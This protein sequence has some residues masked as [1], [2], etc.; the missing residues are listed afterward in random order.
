MQLLRRQR[1]DVTLEQVLSP[2]PD[3]SSP[4]L[5]RAQRANFRLSWAQRLA[6]NARTR[7]SPPISLMLFGLPK[8]FAEAIGLKTL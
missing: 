8:A 7:A 3:P 2:H 4:I 1:A 5:S 6:R